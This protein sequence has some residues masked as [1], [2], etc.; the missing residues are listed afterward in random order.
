MFR[1]ILSSR[2][3]SRLVVLASFAGISAGALAADPKWPHDRRG[4]ND[5][6]DSRHQHGGGFVISFEPRHRSVVIAR[7]DAD[8]CRD[9]VPVDLNITAYQSQDQIIVL[10][11]GCN[12]SGGYT[13]TLSAVNGDCETPELRLKNTAPECGTGGST[14]FTLNAG[15]A[16]WRHVKCIK[17]HIGGTCREVPVTCVQSLS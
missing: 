5:R 12:R 8:V 9:E 16:S 3:A 10:V 6:N 11:T 13:T 15:V 17:V 1:A 4:R 14:R 7:S 2:T